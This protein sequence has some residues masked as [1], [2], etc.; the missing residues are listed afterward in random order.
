MYQVPG[1]KLGGLVKQ[2]TLFP[3]AF[4]VDVSNR[5][6]PFF[7][8]PF[9]SSC[10]IWHHVWFHKRVALGPDVSYLVFCVDTHSECSCHYCCRIYGLDLPTSSVIT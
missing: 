9:V 6:H 8:V 7:R 10:F 4:Q 2:V 1:K 3:C 5:R